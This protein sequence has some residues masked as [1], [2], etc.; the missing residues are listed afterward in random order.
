MSKAEYGSKNKIVTKEEYDKIMARHATNPIF[1][2]LNRSSRGYWDFVSRVAGY[3]PESLR[4]VRSGNPFLGIARLTFVFM[5]GFIVVVPLYIVIGP[6]IQIALV[7]IAVVWTCLAGIF[8]W[9]RLP[10]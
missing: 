4:R 6:V 3:F 10:Q 8:G 7:I 5:A 9:Y 1:Q 2:W